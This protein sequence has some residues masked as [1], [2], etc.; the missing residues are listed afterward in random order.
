VKAIIKNTKDHFFVM[1]KGF[2]RAK[3]VGQK[4]RVRESLIKNEEQRKELLETFG[5]DPNKWKKS[6]NSQVMSA[7]R[8][9]QLDKVATV[10]K[11]RRLWEIIKASGIEMEAIPQLMNPQELSAFLLKARKQWPKGKIRLV[12]CVKTSRKFIYDHRLVVELIRAGV[13][14]SIEHPN[15]NSKYVN[16]VTLGE[17]IRNTKTI[18]VLMKEVEHKS[19]QIRGLRRQ[20]IE[21][22]MQ[23]AKA[24]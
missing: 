15:L 13:V 12:S 3:R 22:L 20:T 14:K 6:D 10:Q 19:P 16:L 2:R 1:E 9:M 18:E 7:V 4:T 23:N 11:R 5:Y 17:E 21:S 8:S 24:I